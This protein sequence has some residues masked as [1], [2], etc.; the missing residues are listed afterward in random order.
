MTAS[1]HRTMTQQRIAPDANVVDDDMS[2]AGQRRFAAERYQINDARRRRW[3]LPAAAK[4]RLGVDD[5]DIDALVEELGIPVAGD[6]P[7]GK[8]RG[9]CI[10]CR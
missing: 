5:I 7:G 1:N 2:E 3:N 4:H 9:R 6:S 8:S 10:L